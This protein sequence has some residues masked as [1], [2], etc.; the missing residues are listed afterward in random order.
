MHDII[1]RFDLHRKS[2]TDG[3]MEVFFRLLC[4]KDAASR[5]SGLKIVKVNEKG[6]MYLILEQTKILAI[7]L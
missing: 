2:I 6:N 5:H 7:A 1:H 3:A 4:S